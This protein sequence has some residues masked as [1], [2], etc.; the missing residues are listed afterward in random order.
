[1]WMSR[2]HAHNMQQS[3]SIDDP[4]LCPSTQSTLGLC[5]VQAANI[6]SHPF[7]TSRM[8]P[9]TSWNPTAHGFFVRVSAWAT[10]PPD[11]M[12]NMMT[13]SVAEKGII[14]NCVHQRLRCSYRK[15][16]AKKISLHPT[17]P[18]KTKNIHWMI[19]LLPTNRTVSSH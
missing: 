15:M 13:A 4:P 1:M 11:M 6:A 7:E 9:L 10:F 3:V 19:L 2:V 14:V 16:R 17:L 12:P 8:Y 5:P 18:P